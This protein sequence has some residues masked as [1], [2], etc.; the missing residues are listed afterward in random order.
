MLVK[1][2]ID[3]K[4]NRR[5]L[6]QQNMSVH[7]C[8]YTINLNPNEWK[9]AKESQWIKDETAAEPSARPNYS[10]KTCTFAE[11]LAAESL[12]A[13]MPSEVRKR[14]DSVV[15]VLFLAQIHVRAPRTKADRFVQHKFY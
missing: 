13:S 1:W 9:R 12:L 2:R 14:T 4:T 7:L 5:A 3:R 11:T 15:V 6:A 8:K 10:G